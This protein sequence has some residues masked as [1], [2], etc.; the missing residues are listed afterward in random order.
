MNW[1]DKRAKR[2]KA[3]RD[4][5]VDTWMALREAIKSA[6]SSFVANYCFDRENFI[7]NVPISTPE[8]RITIVIE[9]PCQDA[10]SRVDIIVD[11]QNILARTQ[12]P[13]TEM[14][15]TMEAS[16]DDVVALS[17]HGRG[18]TPEEAAKIILEPFFFGGTVKP[19]LFPK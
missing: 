18:Y 6:H 5:A 11:G 16:E 3:V 7:I 1:L 17:Y 12:R 13:I 14:L 4:K 8:G 2:D 9:D 15:F 19:R 10:T